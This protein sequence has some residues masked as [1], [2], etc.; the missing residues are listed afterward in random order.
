MQQSTGIIKQNYLIP[1]NAIIITQ[2]IP[3]IPHRIQA[4]PRDPRNTKA[5]HKKNKVLNSVMLNTKLEPSA[6]KTEQM[7]HILLIAL[8]K[9]ESGKPS[10]ADFA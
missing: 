4:R 1:G 3:T 6:N 5:A 8:H 10:D 7:A 9:L 2:D